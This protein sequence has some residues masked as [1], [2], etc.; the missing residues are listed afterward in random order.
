MVIA[1]HP[2]QALRLLDPPTQAERDVLGA[3]GYTRNPAVLHTDVTLLPGPPGIRA[4]WN[5]ELGGCGPDG[6]APRISYH[7]NRLQ[8]LPAGEDYI[9]TLG[10][11]GRRRPADRSST[12]W[13]TRTRPT[14][15]PRSPPSAACPN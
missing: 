5:Y 1:T 7:M 3:F 14:R 13:T 6:P 15:R 10:G 2:D 9:V 4:S 11:A 8:H 12:R